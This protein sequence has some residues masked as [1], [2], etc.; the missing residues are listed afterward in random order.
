MIIKNVSKEQLLFKAEGWEEYY[1]PDYLFYYKGVYCGGFSI[2]NNS[3]IYNVTIKPR[4]WNLGAGTAMMREI[5]SFFTKE[6]YL[7]TCSPK[8]FHIYQKVGFKTEF[9]S[10]S[11]HNMKYERT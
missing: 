6:L 11:W 7:K 8:A 1:I 2:R 4:F 10:G 5:T 9:T 3:Y